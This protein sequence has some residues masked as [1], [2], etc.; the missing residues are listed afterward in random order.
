MKNMLPYDAVIFDLDGTLTRSEEGI[1]KCAAYALDKIGKT[2]ENF[3]ELK[4]F[5]GPPLFYSFCHFAGLTEGEAE[6]AMFF[7][8]ERYNTVGQYENAVYTGI[9][10]LLFR[11]KKQGVYLG[12][13]TGKPQGPTDRILNYFGLTHFFDKVVG[14]DDHD[15]NPS[16][17]KLIESALGTYHYQKAVMIGDRKFDIEG[18]NQNQIDAI[19]VTYGYGHLKELEE[20][21]ATY[22][23]HSVEELANILLPDEK[24]GQY[25]GYFLSMEGGDGSGKSTQV[26]LLEDKLIQWGFDVVKT[27]EPG[28][29]PIAEK[30]RNVVLDIQNTEM[31]AAC[32]ALLYA[33][34]RAQHVQEIIKP[35]VAKGK[36]V[37]C[38]RFVD[39]S[40][41]Y[42][43]GGRELGV[44]EVASI[45]KMAVAGKMPDSTVYLVID[46]EVSLE[47]RKKATALDR[48]EIE[49]K[50][51]HARVQKAY[52][53]IIE[54]DPKRFIL[55]DGT[56]EPAEVGKEAFEKVL[57]RLLE[58]E[59]M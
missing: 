44:N 28:G 52:E 38:D 3:E 35:Q 7:Y 12:V 36:I 6:R 50:A 25:E 47:R 48:I 13:A 22:I 40:I 15:Y 33:A 46:H 31:T 58:R 26:K 5:I 54:K 45:N 19:G 18:A 9:R 59:R 16:K 41:A 34:A 1:M 30:I 43:G 27:R 42:Q 39:S 10:S 55:V 21:K 57:E 49:K 51:F 23:C 37:L 53:D 11:L 14:I 24:P 32:E 17:Q 20:A 2:V 4:H 29:S 8:R 56:K